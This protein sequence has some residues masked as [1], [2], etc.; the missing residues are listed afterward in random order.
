MSS[1]LNSPPP[2]F[3]GVASALKNP[4]F[5]LVLTLDSLRSDPNHGKSLEEAAKARPRSQTMLLTEVGSSR[6]RQTSRVQRKTRPYIMIGMVMGTQ[7][8]FAKQRLCLQGIAITERRIQGRKTGRG[9]PGTRLRLPLL[10]SPSRSDGVV[11]NS[12]HSCLS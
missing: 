5:D 3:Q 11:R 9:W 2:H 6:G 12:S 4:S 7:E 1:H 10:L 8:N